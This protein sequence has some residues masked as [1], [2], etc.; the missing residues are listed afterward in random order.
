[1]RRSFFPQNYLP[2][3]YKIH[4]KKAKAVL[5]PLFKTAFLSSENVIFGL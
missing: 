3:S 5:N 4:E 1:M 2:H